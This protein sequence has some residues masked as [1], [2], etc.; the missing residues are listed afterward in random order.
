MSFIDLWEQNETLERRVEVQSMHI[1]Q[2][3]LEI[4]G[5]DFQAEEKLEEAGDIPTK[6]MVVERL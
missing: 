4:D 1:Q 5:G 3:R 6:E 2:M